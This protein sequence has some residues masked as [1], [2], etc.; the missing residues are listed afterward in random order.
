MRTRRRKKICPFCQA[1]LDRR[2]DEY[3]CPKCNMII[4][5]SHIDIRAYDIIFMGG[6]R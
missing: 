3:V 1:K 2:Q 5:G 6:R 4:S